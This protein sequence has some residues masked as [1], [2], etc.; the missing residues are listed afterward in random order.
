MCVYTHLY[1][2]V[3]VTVCVHILIDLSTQVC[4][5]TQYWYYFMVELNNTRSTMIFN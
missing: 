4:I 2:H 3:H 1:S 5:L